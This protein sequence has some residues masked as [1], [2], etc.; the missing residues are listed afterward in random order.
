MRGGAEDSRVLILFAELAC[1][2]YGDTQ[3]HYGSTHSKILRAST[4]PHTYHHHFI[5]QSAFISAPLMRRFRYDTR[6][7][8]AG[9]TDFFTKAYHSGA[10]FIHLPV[11]VSSFNVEG[12]SSSLSWR[13]FYEDCAI[14]Y[15]YN[16]AFPLLHALKY[17]F[18]IIPRVLIRNAIPAR[19]RNRAR[20]LLGK[21]KS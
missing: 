14:G 10:R 13:M 9:D 15:R 18:Y 21:S 7:K 11:V 3:I 4:R 1:V 16:R 19:F 2:L 6:F 8:I 17:A 20:I 5:H 12:V